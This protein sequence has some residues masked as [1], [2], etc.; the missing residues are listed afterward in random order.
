MK[1]LSLILV[2]LVVGVLAYKQ[3]GGKP[4]P[5][6]GQSSNVTA[7]TP[8]KVPTQPNELKAFEKNINAFVDEAAKEVAKK[9]EAAEGQH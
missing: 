6:L 7:P 3:L 1:F 8:P 2:M 9:I 4:A 5:A